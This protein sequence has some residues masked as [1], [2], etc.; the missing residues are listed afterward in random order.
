MQARDL[1]IEYYRRR[2][3]TDVSKVFI[4]L[5][6]EVGEIALA[7]ERG[8]VDHAK[9]EIV[10]SIALLYHLASIYGIGDIDDNM[11]RIYSKKLES[12]TGNNVSISS[13]Q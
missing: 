1:A 3:G 11:A 13:K 8:N 6:R 5:V 10:E 7:L 2:F 12:I 9:I 4:H